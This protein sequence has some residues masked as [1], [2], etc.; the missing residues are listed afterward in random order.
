MV[1]ACSQPV[2]KGIRKIATWNMKWLG[3]NSGNQLDAV[4]NVSDYGNYIRGTGATLFALQEIGATHSVGGEPKCYY[5]DLIVADLNE[6]TDGSDWKYIIDKVN[7]Q[8]RLAFL[9]KSNEWEVVAD[10]SIR[11]GASFNYIRRPYLAV[12]KSK[13]PNTDYEFIFIN[14]HLKAFPDATEKR[15]ANF[16][17]LA[18]WLQVSKIDS[19]VLIAGDTNLFEGESDVDDALE[20]IGYKPLYD[21][22]ISSIHE[23]KLSQRFDRFFA[24]PGILDEINRAKEVL[25]EADYI[26]VI[27]ENDD[28]FLRWFDDN[29]SDHFPVVLNIDVSKNR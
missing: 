18:K 3:T 28:G 2:E 22:E 14:V 29:I 27:K 23:Y 19:D 11:P 21:R 7:K 17:E 24:S 16:T 12:I 15:R 10:S 4:E 9:F 6:K 8:Q 13:L 20:S 5:L 26:D 1:S 25:G